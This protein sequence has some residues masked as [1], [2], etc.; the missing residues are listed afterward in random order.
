MWHQRIRQNYCKPTTVP[1]EYS[2]T[3][4]I[5]DLCLFWKV[6]KQ[7]VIIELTVAFELNT[8]KAHREKLTN[9]LLLSQASKERAWM[10]HYCS[11]NW[12]QRIIN[13]VWNLFSICAI[14]P[15]RSKTSAIISA[16][17]PSCLNFPTT[18]LTRNHLGIITLCCQFLELGFVFALCFKLLSFLCLY[19][20]PNLCLCPALFLY[21]DNSSVLLMFFLCFVP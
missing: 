20:R 18:T 7:L 2:V 4:L 12:E 6:C 5:P 16:S 19:S 15:W 13:S 17:S 8:E 21:K 1:I 11:W 9:T 10:W 3:N 14:V